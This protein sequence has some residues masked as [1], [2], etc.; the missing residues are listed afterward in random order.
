M[1]Q[2]RFVL[3][4]LLHRGSGALIALTT[5]ALVVGGVLVYRGARAAVLAYRR[6]RGRRVVTCPE[7]HRPAG[8]T[9]D[10]AQAAAAAF[11][12]HA[13]LRLSACSRWPERAGCGQECLSEIASAADGCLV[14]S[15]VRG[16]YAGKRCAFCGKAFELHWHDHRPALLG[17]DGRTREWSELPVE[18]LPDAFATH[19][20]VCWNCHV[21]ESFRREFPELV[22]DRSWQGED[23]HQSSH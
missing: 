6:F 20:A 7:T 14:R 12:G 16:W 10:A 3:I 8:V 21:A 18:Q 2:S 15:L 5:A 11:H 23:R 19:R 1:E 22:V 9:M 17:P 4:D 13:Q